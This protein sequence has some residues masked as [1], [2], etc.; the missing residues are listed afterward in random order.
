VTANHVGKRPDLD[1][2]QFPSPVVTLPAY[3]KVDVAAS[4]A[5]FH[6]ATGKSSLGLTARVDNFFDKRYEDVLRFTS[7]G[8]TILVGARLS[9]SL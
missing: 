8:R 7:P 4:Y 9:G 3:T 1:F 6:S 5:L 2:A